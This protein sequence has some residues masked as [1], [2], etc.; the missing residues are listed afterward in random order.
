M[1]RASPLFIAAFLL[2]FAAPLLAATYT[3]TNCADSGTGSLRQAIIDANAAG[4]GDIVFNIATLECDPAYS[5]GE[6]YSGL[7]TNESGSNAWFR[8][9]IYSKLTVEA[10]NVAVLGST[11]THEA[12]NASG[13]S[14]EVRARGSE[15]NIEV[16]GNY[17]TIEGLVLNRAGPVNSSAGIYLNGAT[18]CHIYG[19]YTG[20]NATGDANLNYRNMQ[21]FR[22]NG[23]SYNVIGGDTAAERNLISGSNQYGIYFL[24]T[25]NSNEVHGNFIGTEIDGFS[26]LNN[27]RSIYILNSS[28]NQIGSSESSRRNIIAGSDQ[29]DRCAILIESSLQN[30]IEGNFIGLGT[31]ETVIGSNYRG[32]DMRATSSNNRIISNV[33][34]G[35]S[36]YGI[37]MWGPNVTS[38]EVLGNYIGTDSTGSVV[39]ANTYGISIEGS[40]YNIIGD[41]TDTGR[42]II[43][44]NSTAIYARGASYNQ[45]Y[46]NYVGLQAD[47]TTA[48]PNNKGIQLV[49]CN[50]NYIGSTEAAKKNI[51]AANTNYGIQLNSS[52]YDNYIEGN[53]IGLA[54]D[55]S[56]QGNNNGIEIAGA[57]YSNH[58]N[59]NVVSGN[60]NHGIYISG[61]GTNSNEV[62]ANY[63]GVDPAGTAEISNEADGINISSNAQYNRIGNGTIS[64]RNVISGNSGS[65]I[66]ISVAQNNYIKGNVIGLDKNGSG[67]I[68][69]NYGVSISYADQNFIG[70]TSFSEKNYIGGNVYDGVYMSDAEDNQI[71]GNYIGFGFDGETPLANRRYGIYLRGGTSAAQNNIIG[72]S[73]SGGGNLIVASSEG[74]TIG[75]FF[76]T[77]NTAN[78]YIY[79]NIIGLTSS[80]SVP[81]S[82]GRYGIQ[83]GGS[84]N[85]NYVGGTGT[86]EKNVISGHSQHGIYITGSNTNSNEVYGNFIGTDSTGTIDRGNTEDGILIESS[87]AFNRIGNGAAAG[88]NII[89][90]NSTSI[91]YAG[92]R[93]AGATNNFIL[94]N[95]IGT[96]VSGEAA[97]GNYHGIYLNGAG[98]NYIGG[99]TTGEGNVICGST[100]QGIWL[101]GSSDSNEI[102]GNTV[103]L[104]KNGLNKLPNGSGIS[105]TN[106]KFNQIGNGASSGSNLVSGN[107]IYG[108]NLSGSNVMSNEVR[109]NLVGVT[110]SG[111]AAAGNG[112]SGIRI[113]SGASFNI[114]GGTGGQGNL[115]SGNGASASEHGIRIEG[116]TT[117]SNEVLGNLIGTDRHGTAAI[118]ND[119]AGI[120]I[121]DAAYNKIGS[122]T[123]GGGNLLSGNGQFG[124]WL[125]NDASHNAVLGNYIGTDINGTADLGNASNG[126]NISSSSNA[127]ANRIG[128]GTA[129]GRNTISGNTG[130]GIELS[131]DG[132]SGTEIF[133]NNIGTNV[134]GTTAIQNDSSG[135][136]ITQ[137]A[138]NE[139][140]NGAAGGLN[141][142]SGNGQDGIEL[143]GNTCFGNKIKT[144]YIGS[145]INGTGN[146]GNTNNGINIHTGASTNEVGTNNIIAFNGI[147]GIRVN[148]SGGFTSEAN[149][150]TRNSIFSNGIQGINLLNNGNH[151]ISSPEVL[152][153]GYDEF[154]GLTYVTGESVHV[155]GTIEVFKAD[156]GQGKTYLNSTTVEGSG[157]WRVYVTGVASG[158]TV[159]ATATTANPETS[160]FSPPFSVITSLAKQYR[161]DN[162]IATLESGADYIG[163]GI[164]NATGAGQTRTRSI[165]TGESA[166]YYVRIDNAGNTTDEVVVTG[167]ASSGDWVIT[168]YDA[169]TGFNDISAQV[170]GAGW[171]TTLSSNESREARFVV[172]NNGTALS[173]LEVLLTSTS[174]YDGSA[175]D[176][177]KASTT[178][179]PVTPPSDLS[180]FTLSA[181]A[182]AVAATPFSLTAIARDSSGAVEHTIIGTTSLS[183]DDG[184]ITPESIAPSSFVNG[185]WVGDVTLSKPG[186]RTITALSGTALG[187]AEITITNATR[188][189]TPT[190]LGIPGMTI[191]VPAGA[192]SQEVAITVSEVTD[193]PGPAPTGYSFGGKILD[194]VASPSQ[195]LLPVTVTIP[196]SSPLRDARVYYW[197]GTAWSRD[198]ISLI[199]QTDT[200]L[201]FTTTH[202]TAFMPAGALA[203]NLV[204]FGPNP[205][206]PYSATVGKIWYWLEHDYDTS[207]YVADIAGN[208]V[209]KRFCA[210]GSNGGR[211][212]SNSVD[213]NGRDR[214]DN[215]LGD[216]VYIYKIVQD[217]KSIGGGKIAIIK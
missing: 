125:Y 101:V 11:Q 113:A 175:V 169:K 145:D 106:G 100:S 9:I 119:K 112:S 160:E 85:T 36:Q 164:Y 121:Y 176:A 210:Y 144:N 209:W 192:A 116:S 151:E 206:N 54:T 34:S 217:G 207:I 136:Y 131:G 120:L 16:T 75:I 159:V 51:I 202:F 114:I 87:A 3:V 12:A 215:L 6:A 43:S 180:S 84:A 15:D 79:N 167:P 185:I 177:V 98:N 50:D 65:G 163:G 61:A 150:F 216:G 69:N 102:E 111:E 123:A 58:V 149:V 188:E 191:S 80:E 178:A 200:S 211:A 56:R 158:D 25:S 67:S 194:I 33:I 195:F 147:D 141:L 203:T 146:L 162:L 129:G 165:S 179:T 91:S 97:I 148:G 168:Y 157:A 89:S 68:G 8:I 26:P 55:E 99:S 59:S 88:R 73:E 201:T 28:Y 83:I 193:A 199:S 126:I 17:A 118:P 172:Q 72:T 128:N 77:A 183:V 14:V 156:N 23:A 32:I 139:I 171:V 137:S 47:G 46:G 110:I 20:M 196:I 189:F 64:G 174:S 92:I 108:I 197:N 117:V 214:W 135:I 142:I 60:S 115:I 30:I 94:G 134:S 152:S 42:N 19:C 155:A 57:S 66:Y 161:P 154:N 1:K 109:S 38:N 107:N 138:S 2:L 81:S 166:V 45:I 78:N 29:I 190:E 103:G 173:T 86:D 13:P 52:N 41:G 22:L 170:T 4:S 31:N 71:Y 40:R 133:G 127:V 49:S 24:N 143:N 63:I 187:T 10:D 122:G 212:G 208:L 74:S 105:I 7:V 96:T 182:S 93:I 39:K 37:L 140:G 90:G 62:Y 130:N 213:F 186:R 104:D 27:N 132:V 204:R 21:G 70:G 184:T 124:I 198:G 95:Y 181:S 48:L 76:T 18:N 53:W 205:Y 5:T 44:G 82:P 35:N 153:A